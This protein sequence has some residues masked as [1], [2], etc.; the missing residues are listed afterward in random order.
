M[1]FAQSPLQLRATTT[2]KLLPPGSYSGT[3]II[4]LVSKV[5]VPTQKPQAGE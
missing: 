1:W 2:E 4:S 5:P 3:T